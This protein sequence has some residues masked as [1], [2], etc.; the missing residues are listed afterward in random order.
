LSQMSKFVEAQT[1]KTI[2]NKGGTMKTKRFDKKLTL[3][4]TTLA[5]LNRSDMEGLK[6]AL[7]YTD[8]GLNTREK[9]CYIDSC[10]SCT[11][12]VVYGTLIHC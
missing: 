5:N 12:K 4:K 11:L 7:N 9:L 3:N 10:V 1:K 6:G 8:A 2:K